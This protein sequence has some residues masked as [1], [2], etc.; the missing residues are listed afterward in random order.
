M[1]REFL[2]QIRRLLP[3][4]R[5]EVLFDDF[6]D[7]N[8]CILTFCTCAFCASRRCLQTAGAAASILKSHKNCITTFWTCVYAR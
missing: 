1:A 5:L 3:G 2:A 7:E 6:D 8:D 4:W